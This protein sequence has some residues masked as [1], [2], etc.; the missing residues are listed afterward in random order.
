M[1]DL[2]QFGL[3]AARAFDGVVE[4][5]KDREQED[6][7]RLRRKAKAHQRQDE[8]DQ[9]HHRRRVER[10][11]VAFERDPQQPH[12]REQQAD[13][14]ADD[15]GAAKADDEQLQRTCQRVDQNAVARIFTDARH[16]RGERR[17][18]RRAGPQRDK[19][20]DHG[21]DNERRGHRRRSRDQ[22][23]LP[24]FIRQSGASRA[25]SPS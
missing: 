15:D 19:L 23:N 8:R 22:S 5:R 17:Q 11:D 1:R 21:A 3:E 14:H 10:H 25:T 12:A 13:Q 6:D 7:Q 24:V 16:R 4:D 9:R 2:D 18:E 20:P